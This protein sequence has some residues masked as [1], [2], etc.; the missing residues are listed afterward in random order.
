MVYCCQDASVLITFGMT[1]FSSIIN[2]VKPQQR[3]SQY[4]VLAALYALGAAVQPVTGSQVIELLELHFGS[5]VPSN[6]PAKLRKYSAYVR[7]ASKKPRLLWS[8]T[9]AGIAK[10]RELSGLSLLATPA[11][12]FGIDVGIICALEQPEFTAVTTA[13]GGPS[14]WREVGSTRYTHVYR[15]TKMV[16]DSG[17]TLTVVG[18]TSSSMADCGFYSYDSADPPISPEDCLDDRHRCGDERRRQTVWG[19]SRSRSKR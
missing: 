4:K 3:T 5:K 2:A 1:D 17:K 8:L 15:E 9:D 16:T 14:K 6:I 18:T 13:L 7:A 10:L 12:A 11:E 19:R